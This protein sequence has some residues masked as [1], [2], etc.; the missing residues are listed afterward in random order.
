V[1]LTESLNRFH[2]CFGWITLDH[3]TRDADSGYETVVASIRVTLHETASR[4]ALAASCLALASECLDN[5]EWSSE[6]WARAA[7]DTGWTSRPT[8]GLGSD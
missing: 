2:K 3:A 7:L 1:D 4:L 6:A 5:A 8:C